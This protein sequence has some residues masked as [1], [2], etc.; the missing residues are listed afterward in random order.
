MIGPVDAALD[1]A[2]EIAL[3]CASERELPREHNVE[4]H[5][6]CPY[7]D[8]LSFIVRLA[9]DLRRHITRC[10]AE[11]FESLGS[12]D[13]HAEAKIDQLHHTRALLDQDVVELDVSVDYVMSV[14]IGDRLSHLLEDPPRCY[15][16]DLAIRKLLGI[17]LEGNAADVVG[18]DKD[19]LRGVYQVM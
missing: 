17:L 6:E 5:A 8:W 16:S 4:E 3:G 13:D 19:L 10:T 1:L 7:I 15:V 9:N 2:V 12:L 18:D 14:T 11:D